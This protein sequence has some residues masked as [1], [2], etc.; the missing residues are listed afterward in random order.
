MILDRTTP[1]PVYVE[2]VPGLTTPPERLDVHEKLQASTAAY[3]AAQLYP[4]P[5]GELLAAE[6]RAWSD[7]GYRGDSNSLVARLVRELTR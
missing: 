6:I 4:G 1:E 7:F 2:P 3:H 5:A